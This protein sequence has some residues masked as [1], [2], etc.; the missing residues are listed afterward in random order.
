MSETRV[1]TPAKVAVAIS[2]VALLLSG[3]SLIL[4]MS[5]DLDQGQIEQRLQC[6]ELPGPNDCGPGR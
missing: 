5:D 4:S 2:V 1:D 6:L 3:W